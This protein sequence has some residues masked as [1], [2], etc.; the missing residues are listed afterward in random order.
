M[1]CIIH[2]TI[3]DHLG[4]MINY[5]LYVWLEYQR[6]YLNN[7]V[8]HKSSYGNIQ[9]IILNMTSSIFE[10]NANITSEK[11]TEICMVMDNPLGTDKDWGSGNV[12]G[13]NKD[14]D[15]N[16]PPGK[17]K[18]RGIGSPMGRSRDWGNSNPLGKDRDW[19][20]SNPQGSCMDIDNLRSHLFHLSRH[21]ILLG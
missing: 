18:G 7:I 10:S 11:Y 14:L 17:D 1:N 13:R 4:I 8:P 21:L 12:M 5:V 20:K 19:D 2:I 9:G 3:L 15:R 6:I 16:N